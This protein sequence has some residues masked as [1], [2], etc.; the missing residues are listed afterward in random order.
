V[1]GHSLSFTRTYS[2]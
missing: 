1:A 2:T